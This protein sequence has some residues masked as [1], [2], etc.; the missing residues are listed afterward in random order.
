MEPDTGSPL[1]RRAH[2]WAWDSFE[3]LVLEAGW[4]AVLPA[5]FC[6]AAL[7]AEATGALRLLAKGLS[8]DSTWGGSVFL[9]LLVAGLLA[10]AGVAA[11]LLFRP[12]D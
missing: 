10:K 9:E 4:W 7:G 2:F 5:A 11:S 8:E 6:E 3:A 12:G 1:D